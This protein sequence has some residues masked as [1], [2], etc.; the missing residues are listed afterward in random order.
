[1]WSRIPIKQKDYVGIAFKVTFPV[2]NTV[3]QID[4]NVYSRFTLYS[5]RQ[6]WDVSSGLFLVEGEISTYIS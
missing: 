4:H 3:N 6:V 5:T 1:M 2:F